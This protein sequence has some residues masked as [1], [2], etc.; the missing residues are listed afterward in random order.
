MRQRERS[1]KDSLLQYYSIKIQKN[2]EVK[3]ETVKRIFRRGPYGAILCD[4][5]GDNG[6]DKMSRSVYTLRPRGRQK[7]IA[8]TENV[9]SE[10]L[11][12][13][14]PGF[15]RAEYRHYE[16]DG[17]FVVIYLSDSK[18]MAVDITGDSLL[19]IAYDVMNALV[20]D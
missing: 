16:K 15:M 12:Q 2:Q 18:Y 1:E 20:K 10:M 11:S 13:V 9:L 3:Y 17:E 8:F 6:G 14:L 5:D 4:T 7:K 19:L